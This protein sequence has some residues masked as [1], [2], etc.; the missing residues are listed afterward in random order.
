M[1]Q[2]MSARPDG[3]AC[4]KFALMGAAIVVF[5]AGAAMA[6]EPGFQGL[7]DL[8]GGT[9]FSE[10]YAISADGSSVVGYS[11]STPGFQAYRWRSAGGML[12]LGD[13]SGGAFSSIGL[14]ASANGNVVVGRG[15]GNNGNEACRY[16]AGSFVALGGTI[17][18]GF[19]G[20]QA[21]A[22]SAE[23]NVI[24]GAREIA[25][26]QREACRWVKVGANY[27]LQGLGDISGGQVFSIA[28]G[29]SSDGSVVVGSGSSATTSEAFRWTQ[30]GGMV[31]LGTLGFEGASGEA[32]S[33]ANACSADG[34]V[35]VGVSASP[36]ESLAFVWTTSTGVMAPL[37]DFAGGAVESNALSCSADGRIIVGYGTSGVGQHAMIW[38]PRS[39]I[40]DLQTKL[41]AAGVNLTGW[42]L[43]QATGISADG[44]SICG[45]GVNP[46]GLSEG[47]VATLPLACDADFNGDGFLDF[48]DFDDFVVA[49][50]A[51]SASA[52]FNADGFLDF[53]DFD[54]FVSSFE[55]GC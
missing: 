22:C 49:F 3:V 53:T 10:A 38:T 28:N 44:T 36:T 15:L 4:V 9:P 16:E 42:T 11:S 33:E 1:H 17:A 51:G 19:L 27:T 20:S 48:T 8:A 25:G 41:A 54:A 24:V 23:A 2:N 34:S 12:G 26:F 32:Y 37:G 39:G 52:D 21:S 40:Q 50:E 14:G 29:C 46:Q 13:L 45:I 5:S 31:S 18:G 7:G 47:W 35:V 30:S 6:V 43:R 55:A